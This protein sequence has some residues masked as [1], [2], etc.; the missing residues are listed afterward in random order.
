[1]KTIL[2]EPVKPQKE[3][4]TLEF[5]YRN[6]FGRCILRV[7][8][9]KWVSV[10][11]GAFL[12]TRLSKFLI[13]SFVKKNGIDLNQYE[14]D[15]FK[16]FN[17]CFS[18]KIKD[19]FRPIDQAEQSLISPADALLSVYKAEHG[20]V[21]PVKQSMYTLNSLLKDNLLARDFYD[22]YVYVFRLCVNHYHRY[23]YPASGKK[24]RNI[25]INGTL[26]TVRPIALENTKVFCENSRE[27]TVIDTYDFGK[28][29]QMEVGAMLVGKIKNLHQERLIEKGEEKG[30]FLY[31]GS[32]VI[33]ITDGN[34][35]PKKEFLDNTLKGFETPIKLG[36]RINE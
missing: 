19:G 10:T 5:L 28:I 13:P 1:M 24:S 25:H 20:S 4:K 21:F 26:H 11:A 12:N 18:R 17:D 22:G 6:F 36:E 34:T 29:I 23:S 27:Y 14:S 31:G 2:S 35:L 33:L 9:A 3:S 32:T 30:M 15:N 16:C 8:R 7:L